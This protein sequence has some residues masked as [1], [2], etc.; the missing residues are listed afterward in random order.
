[1]HFSYVHHKQMGYK[2][3]FYSFDF[4]IHVIYALKFPKL[5]IRLRYFVR[6]TKAFNTFSTK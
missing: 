2:L 4:L 3:N 6:G 5:N 1:M